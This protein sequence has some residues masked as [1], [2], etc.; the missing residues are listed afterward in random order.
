MQRVN[1]KIKR[2]CCLKINHDEEFLLVLCVYNFFLPFFV[3]RFKTKETHKKIIK[4]K[5]KKNPMIAWVA[6]INNLILSSKPTQMF[7]TR[8]HN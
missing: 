5:S 3:F 7:H 2:N 6:K 8:S 4:E 1:I